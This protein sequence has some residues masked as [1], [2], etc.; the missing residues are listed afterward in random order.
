MENLQDLIKR[1]RYRNFKAKN[2]KMEETY[3][4]TIR[5][6][7]KEYTESKAKVLVEKFHM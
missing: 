4:M 5:E 1:Q 6:A 3:M 2:K 7:I